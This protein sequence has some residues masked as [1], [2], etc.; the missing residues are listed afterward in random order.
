MRL[1]VLLC[2][3]HCK[4][5]QMDLLPEFFSIV[6]CLKE[7]STRWQG[8]S[9][10]ED[11]FEFG[12]ENYQQKLDLAGKYCLELQSIHRKIAKNP[13][14]WEEV[15][16][17]STDLTEPRIDGLLPPSTVTREGVLETQNYQVIEGEQHWQKGSG[18]AAGSTTATSS[19]TNTKQVPGFLTS[20]SQHQSPQSPRI[21]R[22]LSS[23]A[24]AGTRD[25][26]QPLAPSNQMT[27]EI[28]DFGSI[29]DEG[30]RAGNF[31]SQ[32]M[33]DELTAM[34]NILLGQQFMEMDRVITFNGTN[35]AIDMDNWQSMG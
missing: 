1:N 29:P 8:L 33:D 7:M 10:S 6:E 19:D 25:L 21:A 26:W 31:D 18:I 24:D 4:Y 35:F 17:Y 32:S 11:S 23:D 2:V 13:K 15:L 20:S 14:L 27:P 9:S 28:L 12:D 5:Y 34:S 22:I 30:H 3:V 16:G